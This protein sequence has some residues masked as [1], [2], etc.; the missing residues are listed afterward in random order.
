MFYDELFKV[1]I[2]DFA[3]CPDAVKEYARSV[4]NCMRT[5][6][7]ISLYHGLRSNRSC[8]E[9]K[10]II[11]KLFGDLEDAIL[12][13]PFYNRVNKTGQCMVIKKHL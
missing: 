6:F 12:S 13:N 11:D 5:F 3:A 9:K 4:A 10:Q 1:F 2:L 8:A 7:Y